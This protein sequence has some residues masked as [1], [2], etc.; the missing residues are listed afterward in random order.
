[1]TQTGDV[2]CVGRGIVE[3]LPNAFW[4][5]MIGCIQG[6]QAAV[7]VGITNI[8]LESNATL[9]QQAVNHGDHRASLAGCLLYRWPNGSGMMGRHGPRPK[10]HDT[11]MV[12][13]DVHSASAGTGM[14]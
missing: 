7:H 13:H 3:F 6:V 12:R 11:S 14:I 10:K 2:V 5:E 1:V 8:I 9:V 4:A